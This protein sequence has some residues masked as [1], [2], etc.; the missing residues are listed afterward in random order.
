[1]IYSKLVYMKTEVIGNIGG[2]DCSLMLD[3]SKLLPGEFLEVQ[4]PPNPTE[5]SDFEVNYNV[6]ARDA[7]RIGYS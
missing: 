2:L 7:S 5:F 4:T 6:G 3:T 1:M